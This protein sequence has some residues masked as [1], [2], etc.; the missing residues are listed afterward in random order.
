MLLKEQTLRGFSDTI[1]RIV[2]GGNIVKEF[3]FFG[4]TFREM[5]PVLVKLGCCM[6]LIIGVMLLLNY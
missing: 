2:E 3:T 5:V 1:K 6:G 4:Y